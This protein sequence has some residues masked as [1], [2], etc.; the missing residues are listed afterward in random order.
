MDPIK[1]SYGSHSNLSNASVSKGQIL[2]SINEEKKSGEIYFGANANQLIYMGSRPLEDTENVITNLSCSSGTTTGPTLELSVNNTII[3]NTLIPVATD[4]Q[5]GVI[6]TGNQNFNG[7]KTFYNSIIISREKFL[8]GNSELILQSGKFRQTGSSGVTYP[9]RLINIKISTTNANAVL[10]CYHNS[11]FYTGSQTLTNTFYEFQG[12]AFSSYYTYQYYNN[13]VLNTAQNYTNIL[14]LGNSKYPWNAGYFSYGLNL[15]TTSNNSNPMYKVRPN[16]RMYYHTTVNT[17]G[18]YDY[19]YSYTDLRPNLYGL[20]LYWNYRN[21]NKT[22]NSSTYTNFYYNFTNSGFF[23]SNANIK[24]IGGS[25]TTNRWNTVYATTFDG[26]I[27]T[28]IANKAEALNTPQ[29]LSIGKTSKSFDGSADVSWTY[30]EIGADITNFSWTESNTIGPILN[31]SVNECEIKTAEIPIASIDRTGVISTGAQIIQGSKTLTDNLYIG[32]SVYDINYSNSPRIVLTAKPMNESDAT[33]SS[34]EFQINN[35][36]E[37]GKYAQIV[38]KE[39]LEDDIIIMPASLYLNK[40][41]SKL[42][43]KNTDDNNI[44]GEVLLNASGLELTYNNTELNNSLLLNTDGVRFNCKN[45]VYIFNDIGIIPSENLNLGSVNTPWSTVYANDFEGIASSARA[46]TNTFN[47]K[48]N[49]SSSDGAE[50][51][52][53][54]QDSSTNISLG[55]EGILP[56]SFGGTGTNLSGVGEGRALTNLGIYYGEDP[57]IDPDKGTIWLCPLKI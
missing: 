7:T 49:L 43:Y 1:F 57:P 48:V 39:A 22:S 31:L 38:Y 30:A 56:L 8:N 32:S 29:N 27:F 52:G 36:E 12:Q 41:N 24:N 50:F 16:I 34:L 45:S 25:A 17:N 9:N 26:S 55:V 20:T 19:S 13:G 53:S 35:E 5:S 14:N 11:S 44:F 3:A 15:G 40:E 10:A 51:N 2:F 4:I 33:Y 28:G 47:F 42:T 23:A 6:N 37:T 21:F 54:S 46:L 18:S